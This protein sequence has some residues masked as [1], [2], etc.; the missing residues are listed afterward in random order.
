MLLLL[1]RLDGDRY[2]L[3]AR[4]V[5]EV[6]PAVRLKNIPH[7]PAYVAGLFS[8][9]GSPIPVIDLC[10]L[11]KGKHARAHLSSRIVVV[12]Y[13][14][15][16]DE[17]Q[18]LGILA[19]G[20]TEVI[21]RDDIEFCDTGMSTK[22]APYLGRVAMDEEELIQRIEIEPLL[23]DAVRET[24]FGEAKSTDTQTV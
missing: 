17:K 2:A 1:I 16:Q 20:V 5:V 3:D 9:R 6:I 4:Q 7:A 13:P 24:L 14:V 10:C 22:D 23:D 21:K 11:T 12:N 15:R 19:E 18:L 8:F